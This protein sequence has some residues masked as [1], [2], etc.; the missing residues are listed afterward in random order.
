[1]DHLFG[2]QRLG[3]ADRD[4][5]VDRDAGSLGEGGI[6]FHSMPYFMAPE[7]QRRVPALMWFGKGLRE[8][9][10]IERLRIRAAAESHHDMLAHT[11]L[12]L[13]EVRTSVYVP[14]RDIL[15]GIWSTATD[16][17]DAKVAE[18]LGKP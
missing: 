15:N 10:D 17:S 7:E 16:S 13:L 6:Y 5:P 12:G 14:E 11:L 9:M 2:R 1:M 8:R 3:L 18:G 4:H